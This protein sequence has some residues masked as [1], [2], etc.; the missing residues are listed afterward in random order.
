MPTPPKTSREEI[1][2]AAAE[3]LE[4]GG[5][6]SVT[7]LGVAKRV[8]IRGASLYKHFPDLTAILVALEEDNFREL[9]QR[10]TDAERSVTG[11]V[12]GYLSF[13]RDRPEQAKLLFRQGKAELGY[14]AMRAPLT[15]LIELLGDPEEALVRLRILTCM[16][17]GYGL[18]IDSGA[19]RQGGDVG[20]VLRRAAELIVPEEDRR[21]SFPRRKDGSPGDLRRVASTSLTG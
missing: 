17:H 19:F 1:L 16:L 3:M 21:K 4:V 14:E 13:V 6:R 11:M 8:G 20:E 18:M 2:S 10:L 15:Y 5:I 12:N 7:M 9:G